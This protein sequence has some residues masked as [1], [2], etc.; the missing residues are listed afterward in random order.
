MS[1]VYRGCYTGYQYQFA[2]WLITVRNYNAQS[3]GKIV[4]RR[5]EET[6]SVVRDAIWHEHNPLCTCTC[7]I[8]LYM[9]NT[10]MTKKCLAKDRIELRIEFT[11]VDSILSYNI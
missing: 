1:E 6:L 7:T 4:L 3:F 10:Y 9:D 8:I 11:Q 2:R 5:N